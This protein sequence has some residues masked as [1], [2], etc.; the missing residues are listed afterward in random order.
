M[1]PKV[2]AHCKIGTPEI[3]QE[4]TAGVGN[5]RGAEARKGA[6]VGLKLGLSVPRKARFGKT[7]PL[8]AEA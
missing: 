6:I 2:K 7:A 4:W 1:S 5:R 3:A 8:T